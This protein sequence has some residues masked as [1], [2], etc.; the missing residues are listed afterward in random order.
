MITMSAKEA[1]EN[2]SEILGTVRYGDQSVL[3][4][5]Q[6]KPYAVL[7]SPE[8]YNLLQK[9]AKSDLFEMIDVLHKDMGDVDESSIYEEVASITEEIRKEHY[10]NRATKKT[11]Y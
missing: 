6:G 8:D 2:F 5:K 10:E 9:K 11:R 4:E 3:V 1:R 7:I